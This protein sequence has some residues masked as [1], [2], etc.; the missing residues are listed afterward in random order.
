MTDN[1][2]WT[3]VLAKEGESWYGNWGPNDACFRSHISLLS[4]G[5]YRVHA[6]GND[7][8]GM[9]IDVATL[10]EAAS[11]FEK[12]KK[13]APENGTMGLSSKEL[14]TLGFEWF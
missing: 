1:L 7:D 8:I 14:A 9:V 6:W 2:P 13:H 11:L 3:W 10:A 12:L 5:K 4:D